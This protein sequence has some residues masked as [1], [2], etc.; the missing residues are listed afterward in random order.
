MTAKPQRQIGF[1]TATSLVVGTVV[2]SGIFMLP[3]SMATFGSIGLIGWAMSGFG[4][5]FLALCFSRLS[6]RMPKAGGPYA[7]CR[8]AYG[9]MVA[10]QV[11]TSYWV[12]GIVSIS[13]ISIACASYMSSLMPELMGEPHVRA[14]VAIGLVALLAGVNMLGVKPVGIFQIVTSAVKLIPL[15]FMTFVGLMFIDTS[16]FTPM[17]VSHMPNM[18][19]VMAAAAITFFSFMGLESATVPSDDVVNPSKTIPRA[20]MV[21]T[22]CVIILYLASATAVMGI[23]PLDVLATSK[24]PFSLAAERI[25][26]LAYGPVAGTFITFCAIVSCLG[27]LNGYLLLQGKMPQAAAHD[28]LFP[29]LFASLN[30]QG[31][32]WFGL[33][34]CA[35]G[36]SIMIYLTVSPTVAEQFNTVCLIASFLGLFVYAYTSIAEVVIMVCDRSFYTP[37]DFWRSAVV[38][39]LAFTYCIWAMGG[40]G[41]KIGFMGVLFIFATLPIYVWMCWRNVPAK[42]SAKKK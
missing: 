12:R 37:Q 39:G 16:H 17:N 20:T 4:A 23:V 18:E 41:A 28:N 2:G 42:A 22:V 13:A 1:W 14:F 36:S 25:F 27:A 26:G 9:D 5:L 38:G 6:R 32:P 10:F 33:M 19:A 15:I 3:A 11:A 7:Y 35:I 8:Q 40:A 29:K 34:T 30:K 21:G 24:A 31:A